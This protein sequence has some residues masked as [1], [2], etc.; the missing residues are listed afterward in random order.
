[1]NETGFIVLHRKL[2]EWKYFYSPY[3]LKLWI[4]LLLRA[5]WKTGYFLGVEIPRGS[6]A[7]SMRRLALDTE[8]DVNTVRK[9]IKRFQEE[10]MITV[11]TSNRFTHIFINNYATFQDIA[12]EQSSTQH[13]TESHTQSHTQRPPNRTNKQSNKETKKQIDSLGAV[14]APDLME[15]VEYVRSENLG[16]N[17]EKFYRFYH[18]KNWMIN[19]D[20][21]HNWKSL[22]RNWAQNERKEAEGIKI[23]MPQYGQPPKKTIDL[24]TMPG[25]KEEEE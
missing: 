1:M 14:S 8:M 20:P 9:W 6:L 13:H 2:L 19:G 18:E 16:V 10:D 23:P 21:I 4:Y 5:N 22:L 7:T 12:D 25:W 17:P 15:V 3:A 24:T 11:K